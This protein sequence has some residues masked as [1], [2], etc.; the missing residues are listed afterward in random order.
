M[1]F[2][3]WWAEMSCMQQV[4]LLFHDFGNGFRL[5]ISS[6]VWLSH[7]SFAGFQIWLK[8]FNEIERSGKIIKRF[9]LH[10]MVLWSGLFFFCFK[11]SLSSLDTQI[12]LAKPFYSLHEFLVLLFDLSLHCLHS[13]L[14]SIWMLILMP[15]YPFVLLL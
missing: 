1:D 9:P 6:S 8:T 4:C 14:R 12:L 15:V 5:G 11:K 7:C 13:L 3:S 2:Y 10:F